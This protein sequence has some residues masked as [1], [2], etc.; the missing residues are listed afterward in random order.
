MHEYLTNV[1]AGKK[2]ACATTKKYEICT[3][4]VWVKYNV[5]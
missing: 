4:K 2:F 5:L 3:G 1:S